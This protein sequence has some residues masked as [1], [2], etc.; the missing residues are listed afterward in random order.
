M[1]GLDIIRN[2]PLTQQLDS[3][4]LH[5]DDLHSSLPGGP[6]ILSLATPHPE[7]YCQYLFVFHFA[8]NSPPGNC[9]PLLRN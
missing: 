7:I 9:P 8:L 6:P 3:N 4:P 2:K 1:G 5:S